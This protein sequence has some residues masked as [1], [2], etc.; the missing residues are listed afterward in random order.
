MKKRKTKTRDKIIFLLTFIFG[1]ALLLSVL[2]PYVHP[3]RSS[4]PAL[5]GLFFPV[6]FFFNGLFLVYWLTRLRIYFLFTLVFLLLSANLFFKTFAFNKIKP[7]GSYDEALKVLSYNVRL[8][9]QFKWTG[10]QNY[11]TR[12]SVFEFVHSQQA[13]VICFQEFFH[14]NE[15]YFPTIGPFLE[16]TQANHYHVDYMKVTGESKHFGLATFSR[17]PIVGKGSIRFEN[18]VANS[19]IYT[20]IIFKKDTVRVFNFHLESIGFS[21]A[22]QKF[23][24]E[25]IYPGS[26]GGSTNLST[27]IKKLITAFKNRSVQI[28]VV[29]EK[30]MQSPYPVIVCGDFN[31]TPASFAYHS[32]ARHLEDAFLDA[33]SGLGSTYAGSFPFLRIDYMLRDPVLE[34]FRFQVHDVNYSD[35]YPISCYFKFRKQD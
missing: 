15:K 31:D 2:S 17:F 3:S 11:F 25:M 27:I 20:D 7:V 10:N 33:G 9:D 19:G 1:I 29:T 4:I 23:V 13:D 6:L 5:F 21:K 24:S 30:I 8:F 12:N 14:G 32:V 28:E 34:A 22:D 35:H 18:A 26:T 16:K